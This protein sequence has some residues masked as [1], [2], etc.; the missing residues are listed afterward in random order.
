MKRKATLCDP[1]LGV[2]E[3]PEAPAS[4]EYW[5]KMRK[6]IRERLMRTRLWKEGSRHPCPECGARTFIGS[7]E[8]TQEFRRGQRIIVMRN[9]A[10]ARCASCGFQMLEPREH[11]HIDDE[12]EILTAVDHDVGVSRVGRGTLGTYW[13]KGLQRELRL[14]PGTR[15]RVQVLSPSSALLEVRP[16]RMRRRRQGSKSRS[17]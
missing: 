13:P 15:L 14:R 17:G 10:G 12:L 7:D 5:N 9:L 8:V 3:L 4:P 1:D 2:I 6:R 16:G 11:L